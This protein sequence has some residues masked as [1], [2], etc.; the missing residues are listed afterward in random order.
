MHLNHNFQSY[1]VTLPEKDTIFEKAC[2]SSLYMAS[3]S[4][5]LLKYDQKLCNEKTVFR[6]HFG[7]ILT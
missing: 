7:S 2:E 5:R 3:S 6:W 4:L 1:Y